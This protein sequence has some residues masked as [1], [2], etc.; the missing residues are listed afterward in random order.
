[1]TVEHIS[2]A[3]IR[4]LQQLSPFELKNKLAALAGEHERRTAFQMLNAGR[5]NPNFIAPTPRDAF[6]QLGAFGLEESRANAEWDP[7]LV[8]VPQKTGIADRF[9]AWLDKRDT[10]MGAELLRRTLD[11]G[12]GEC[13]FDPDSFVW[14]LADA[15]IGDHYPEPDRMLRHNEQVVHRY[16]LR[17]MCGGRAD[18]GTFDLFAVEGGTAAMCYI[19]N[20]L[21][22][23][24]LAHPGD[25]VALMVPI[26]TPYLEITELAEFDF[27]RVFIDASTT[28]PEG[29][30]SWQFPDSEIDKLLDPDVKVLFCVN[31]TNPPSVR[32]ADAALE[33]IG[34][35]V[36]DKR[37]DLIIITDDVYGTFIDGFRSLMS[38]CPQNTITVYS[39]SK[40]FGATGWRLGVI[41]VN[42]DSIFDRA[43]AAL[44]EPDKEALDRRY[45]SLTLTPRDLRFIDRMVADSRNVALN[46]TAG[47]SLPQQMMMLLFS[48]YCLLDED[49][50]Y[51][52]A[53]QEL[54]EQRLAR[55]LGGLDIA[56]FD[57]PNRVG[58]YIELDFLNAAVLRHGAELGEF[59]KANYEPTDLLFRL[60]E[61]TGIVLMNGGGFE[62][63]AWS[64]RVSLANLRD[65]QYDQIGRSL[66]AIAGQ[67][68]DEWRTRQDGA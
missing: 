27:E 13:G 10:N 25:K 47:L 22:V 45:G 38:V 58:Y 18:L 14:E 4:E 17:E 62:G 48:A 36:R 66:R 24:R 30:H 39:Y 67:Y 52:H 11:Y 19:F 3:E 31:P 1:V 61:Q 9:R 60:A 54:I 32:I 33:R 43:L 29:L 41:A 23:N 53:A 7:E 49:D 57:D 63:P 2:R 59:L 55:L 44:P 51:K 6:F 37:P 35:I 42:Q 12:I 21:L 40:Y 20:S 8:G 34:A 28:T 64:V 16:L 46:H 26:F 56:M 15:I 68:F 65:E 5:G 50:H